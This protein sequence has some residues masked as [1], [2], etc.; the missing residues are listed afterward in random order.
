VSI[1]LSRRDLKALTAL[2]AMRDGRGRALDM[3]AGVGDGTLAALAKRGLLTRIEAA[4]PLWA[5]TERGRRALAE[6][7]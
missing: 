1:D 3:P 7:V 6:Y 4:E 2:A 5:I